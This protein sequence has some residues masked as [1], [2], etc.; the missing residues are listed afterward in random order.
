M[1][2]NWNTIGIPLNPGERMAIRDNF[3]KGTVEIMVLS[4][5]SQEDMYGYQLSQLIAERSQHSIEVPEGSLYPTL[6]RLLNNGYISDRRV[7][8]GRRMTRIYY[9]IEP[10]G[11]ERLKLLISEYLLFADG[12]RNIIS[13]AEDLFEEDIP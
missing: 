3:K 10:A 8:V 4:L 11:I 2:L 7:Q 6:Y 9:H 12:L 1:L 13:A 5:L